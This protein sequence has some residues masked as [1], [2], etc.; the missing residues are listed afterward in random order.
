ML[1]IGEKEAE[2]ELV[3]VRQ[4]LQGDLGSMSI[5]AFTK[6]IEE[7]IENELATNA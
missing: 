7:A 2:T 3:S 5:D 1:I 6:I 4:R